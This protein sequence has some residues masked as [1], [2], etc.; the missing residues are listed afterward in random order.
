MSPPFP[1]TS[2]FTNAQSCIQDQKIRWSQQILK[3]AVQR[4]FRCL[5]K[6]VLAQ[7]GVGPQKLRSERNCSLDKTFVGHG[8]GGEGCIACRQWCAKTFVVQYVSFQRP[9]TMSSGA[10]LLQQLQA[11]R[12]QQQEQQKA[13]QAQEQPESPKAGAAAA[14]SG[15]S[16][17]SNG[18]LATNSTPGPSTVCAA[19]ASASR[20]ASTGD[21]NCAIDIQV[22]LGPDC[23]GAGGGAALLE[24]EDLVAKW[25]PAGA[26][27]EGAARALRVV[28]GG[29]RDHCT[30][31]PNVYVRGGPP[32][33]SVRNGTGDYD[34]DDGAHFTKVSCP[35]AC[36]RVVQAA[37]DAAG[38]AGHSDAATEPPAGAGRILQLR[39]AG[40]RWRALRQRAATER[41]LRVKERVPTSA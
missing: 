26:A 24:I 4:P 40:R 39:E 25:C 11:R 16:P 15:S 3:T 37:A 29:C 12:Q 8:A 21:S 36:R 23:S 27:A 5:D 34:P 1:S 19:A 30:M 6:P 18:R 7:G 28:D 2:V 32:R 17:S 14:A 31:G 35:A 41:R 38:V 9:Q 33:R 13:K 22:C 20:A 10:L